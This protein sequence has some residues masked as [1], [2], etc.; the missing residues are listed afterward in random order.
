MTTLTVTRREQVVRPWRRWVLRH[1]GLRAVPFMAP[2]LIGFAVFFAYPLVSTV[3]F[4]FTHYDQINPP[5][6][7]GL[8]NWTYVFTQY[9][10]FLTALG[11]SVW[12]VLVMV[13]SRVVFGLGI[14]LLITKV[15][16]GA[17]FFRTFFYLPYLA[18][19]V[20]ATI[21]FAF[22]LNPGTGP[23]NQLLSSVGIQP[24]GWFNDATWSKP[25]LTMLALWGIGDLMVIFMASLLDVSKEQ[26]EAASLDGAGAIQ[27]FRHITLPTISPI[28]TFAVITGVIQ[29]MQYYT[30]AVIA[31]KVASGVVD[32]PGTAFDAG[33]PDGSTLTLP[34]LVYT[35]GFQHFN[36]G[37]A[38][39][40]SIVLFAVAMAFTVLLLRRGSGFLTAED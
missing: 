38:C 14:G 2:W 18:P 36:T 15:K 25:A 3:Y 12:L 27:Q 10:Q 6:F 9:P 19:P 5:T 20:A 37:A 13:T 17:G 28:I 11:N 32:A 23:V 30:Q 31:G 26:Y 4:S 7:V 40:V 21:A 24:P 16:T 39:V 8:R 22:L 35:L 29:T 34:Q 1:R 33:Y